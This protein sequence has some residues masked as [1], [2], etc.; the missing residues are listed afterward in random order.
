MSA[1][2]ADGRTAVLVPD[3][4]PLTLV[5]L[6]SGSSR[7]LPARHDGPVKSAVFTPDSKTLVTT[8]DDAKVV[9]WD[10]RSAN[11]KADFEGHADGVAGVAIAPD[12]R[13][14]YTAGLDGTVIAWDLSGA[15]QL[16]RQ[17]TVARR[18]KVQTKFAE[19]R[20]MGDAAISW[21]VAASPNGDM[22]AVGTNDGVVNVIDGRTLRIARR[23]RVNRDWGT[24]AMFDRDG[25]TI[26]V[27]ADWYF[28]F[29]D[30]RTGA[31]L[32]RRLASR[33]SQLWG[34]RISAD[35][36][37]VALTG[38][39]HLVRIWDARRFEE[40]NT[41][42]LDLLPRDLSM[43]PDG[44]IVVV[45]VEFGAGTGRVEV[46]AVPSLKT[47]ARI[48]MLHTRWSSFSRDG[49][50]FIVG[51]HEGRAQIFDGHT[52][53]P[54]GRLLVGHAGTITNA[55]FSPDGRTV[56]TGSGDGT[57]R[58]WDTAT[59]RPIARPL[60][61]LPNVE[62]GVAFMG[63]N[64]LA[65]VYDTGQAYLW[66]VRP[67]SWLRRAC[68]VAGRPLTRQ[69]WADVLPGREYEPACRP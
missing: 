9:V 66:D 46:L 53:K 39:D 15:R 51:D 28:G 43:R 14:A 18:G 25:R 8:G 57:V 21:N 61:G 16:G 41:R 68:A 44:K 47:V 11:S 2:S 3:D 12:G 34:P 31:R 55:D 64:R 7:T 22:L 63:P 50:M 32:Q 45:P 23:I 49:R 36:R 29:W 40:V 59:G 35:G 20:S 56:A 17:F 5:D 48:P 10:V 65:A 24:N 1:V 30:A 6:R 26:A 69:E 54:R 4:G 62:V 52:F 19:S 27:A 38:I 67:S 33:D 58:L 60:P 42:K 37:W 13:T